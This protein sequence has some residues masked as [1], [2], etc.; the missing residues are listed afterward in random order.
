MIRAIAHTLSRLVFIALLCVFY[1]PAFAADL[2][3][4]S[5]IEVTAEAEIEAMPDLAIVELGVVAQA[6]TAAAAA[7]RNAE[8]MQAVLA[9]LRRALGADTRIETS[10]YSV[11]PDYTRPREGV[12]TTQV[13]GYTARNTV[14]IMLPDLTRVGTAVDTAV[15]AGGNQV[16]RVSFTL[17]EPT[18]AQ[19]EALRR[20][21]QAA[22]E[23]ARTA[24]AALGLQVTGFYTVV[25]HE[26]GGV[27]PVF[28]EGAMFARAETAA[29][30]PVEPGRIPVRGRVTLTVRVGG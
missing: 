12:S 19:N 25:V 21:I 10:A 26:I 6:Q 5:T 20:A 18:I 1:A 24:A 2:R 28:Q 15:K 3:V 23:K 16:Q 9:A 22:Q 4:P 14:R 29:P 17:R 8:Q 30:T 13:V 7:Q 11:N 27:R